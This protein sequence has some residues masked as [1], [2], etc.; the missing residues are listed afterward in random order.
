MKE[1]TIGYTYGMGGQYA[2][3]RSPSRKKIREIFP[4]VGIWEDIP[5][6]LIKSPDTLKYLRNKETY[7]INELPEIIIKLF[8]RAEAQDKV[9]YYKKDYKLIS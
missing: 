9:D 3:I 4:N 8:L 7:N 1:F 5:P 2:I 6:W